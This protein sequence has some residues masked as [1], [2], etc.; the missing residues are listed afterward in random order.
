M[1]KLN[2]KDA[3]VYLKKEKGG[4]QGVEEKEL[5]KKENLHGQLSLESFGLN[6]VQQG[7]LL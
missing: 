7:N 6:K 2:L 5:K 4:G 1:E 3:K